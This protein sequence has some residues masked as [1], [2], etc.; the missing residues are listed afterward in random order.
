MMQHLRP[1]EWAKHQ[2][3][4]KSA[5]GNANEAAGGLGSGWRPAASAQLASSP[6][7]KESVVVGGTEVDRQ[8]KLQRTARRQDVK[9]DPL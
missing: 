9:R 5:I 7:A 8:D 4:R 1:A 2:S 3:E 6:H